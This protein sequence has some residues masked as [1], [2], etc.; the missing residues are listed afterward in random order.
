MNVNKL[1]LNFDYTDMKWNKYAMCQ[2]KPSQ[3]EYKQLM[4]WLWNTHGPPKYEKSI[5]FHIL[6]L[7]L[8]IS[9]QIVSLFDMYI[10]MGERI[11]GKRDRP[12]PIM[13][14]PIR[15]PK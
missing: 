8:Q 11:A 7:N 2:R 5:I 10:D 6:G 13:K 4:V 1:W 15:A 3:V 14:D 9:Y 12:S